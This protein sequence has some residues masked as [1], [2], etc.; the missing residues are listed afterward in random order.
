MKLIIWNNSYEYAI[1]LN[2]DLHM[3]FA[4]SDIN[5]G[6]NNQLIKC[7]TDGGANFN[8]VKCPPK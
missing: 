8:E 3:S 4:W 7:S 6:N 5:P 2:S 1:G